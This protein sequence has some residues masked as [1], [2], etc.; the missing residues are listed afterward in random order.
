LCSGCFLFNLVQ[1][2]AD[3]QLKTQETCVGK[4]WRFGMGIQHWSDN[5]I[6]VDLPEEPELV[7]EIEGLVEMIGGEDHCS[8]VMD[9]SGVD[10]VTSSSLS[11]LLEL[12]KL[13]VECGRR[14]IFCSLPGTTRGVLAV[15]GLDQVFELAEDKFAALATIEMIG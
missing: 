12:R 4:N 1:R 10:A 15:T 2:F 9:F 5:I 6:I 7:E 3:A 11:K 14:L 13:L 8:V